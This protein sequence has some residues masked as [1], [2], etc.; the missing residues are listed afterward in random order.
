M[1]VLQQPNKEI[2]R[3]NRRLWIWIVLFGFFAAT[4]P[5]QATDSD[6]PKFGLVFMGTGAGQSALISP[7]VGAIWQPCEHIALSPFFNFTHSWRDGYSYSSDTTSANVS[8]QSANI[9]GVGAKL[10]LYFKNWDDIRLYVAPGYAYARSHSKSSAQQ[11]NPSVSFTSQNEIKSISHEGSGVWGIQYAVNDRISLFGEIG[12]TYQHMEYSNTTTT[13]PEDI[14]GTSSSPP[15]PAA[16]SV[17]L[18]N[19]MG[20]IFCLK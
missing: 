16:N 18:K 8:P 12:V 17:G 10:P 14:F 15:Q 11:T 2:W 4:L 5:A 9:F 13:V 3:M 1:R 6:S 20:V 19:S 7:G